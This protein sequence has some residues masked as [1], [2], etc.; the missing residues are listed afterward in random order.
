MSPHALRRAWADHSLNDPVNPAPLDVVSAVLNHSE[1][2]TTRRHYAHTN[3]ERA[4]DALLGH[5]L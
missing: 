4:R 5:R 1:T 3:G 2:T